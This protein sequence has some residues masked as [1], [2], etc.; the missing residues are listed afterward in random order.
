M[1]LFLLASSALAQEKTATVTFFRESKS[2]FKHN[3]QFKNDFVG[4]GF[5]WPIY[6]DGVLL[7]DL[8]RDRI[9]TFSII[10]GHHEFKSDKSPRLAIDVETGSH[11]FIRPVM[12]FRDHRFKAALSLQKVNCLDF[13]DRADHIKGIK[14]EDVF[15]GK[16]RPNSD[17]SKLCDENTQQNH[18]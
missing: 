3:E 17:F 11:I 16:L 4:M 10:P 1:V 13:I 12:S 2:Q 9:A 15:S 14:P 7:L 18:F 5:H 8:R 6:M